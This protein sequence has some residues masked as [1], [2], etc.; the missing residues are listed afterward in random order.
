MA[1]T[2]DFPFDELPV[3]VCDVYDMSLLAYGH[4][5][6]TD[7]GHGYEGEF[8][9]SA[10]KLDSGARLTK[11]SLETFEGQLFR[12][13]ADEIQNDR[14]PIGRSAAEAWAEALEQSRQP[15]PDDARDR[16]R[17]DAA[18]FSHAFA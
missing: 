11:G 6:L 10:I 16:R 4:A 7:A 17:D 13:I 8:Y 15:D 12:R 2:I 3:M 9:V 1:L 5:E 18:Y 14:C